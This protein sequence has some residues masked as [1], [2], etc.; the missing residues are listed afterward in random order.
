M[1]LPKS[2]LLIVFCLPT[3]TVS[4]ALAQTEVHPRLFLKRD[5][6]DNLFL[7]DTNQ[8]TDWSTTIEPGIVLNYQ[9]PSVDIA[10]DYSLRYQFYQKHNEYNLEDFSE[11]Q[12]TSSSA[13]F[14]DGHPF[15][16]R[17][18]AD[19]RRDSLD[20]RNNSSPSNDLVNKFTVYDL[21]ATPEYRWQ[22]VP[23]FSIIFSY[24][25]DRTEVVGDDFD[26]LAHRGTISLE[27]QL[28]TNSQVVG[29]Y[30]YLDQQ[31]ESS[32]D[33]NLQEYSLGLTQDFGPNLSIR[34][35]GG[36]AIVEY[37]TGADG[38]SP[39]W[40]ATLSYQISTPIRLHLEYGQTFS[41]SQIDGLYKDR[42]ATALLG[43][44]SDRLTSSVDFF[45]EEA[46][47]VQFFRQDQTWG[48]RFNLHLMLTKVYFTDLDAYAERSNYKP[49]AEQVDRYGL[50]GA[51]GL[52]YRR[53]IMSLS[54]NYRVNDSDLP[55]RD[56]REKL[57]ALNAALRF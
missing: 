3:L 45:W 51:I 27:K 39:I 57:F 31:A 13:L 40:S 49:V 18:N 25:Y 36:E 16:L 48:S 22:L 50:G 5:Y 24:L 54:V 26:S 46:D 38:S 20:V 15:T 12:R 19:I 53:I 4:V 7:A 37:D 17:L 47:Y 30:R 21:R 23:S 8:Q 43:Y 52:E 35:E 10:L 32:D 41:L 14:F 42:S 11:V 33:Y 1:K 34:V 28:S 56:Y 6:T 44:T 55:T 2:L 9:A 29:S